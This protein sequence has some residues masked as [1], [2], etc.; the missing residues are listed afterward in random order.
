MSED[1]D[2]FFG[3]AARGWNRGKKAG[4]EVAGLVGL[5][6]ACIKLC[7][8]LVKWVVLFLPFTVWV[9]TRTDF[10]SK[11]LS[12]GNLA[13]GTVFGFFTIAFLIGEEP[14]DSMSMALA[15]IF[16][17]SFLVMGLIQ[18]I[19]AEVRTAKGKVHS[20]C[21]GKS[22]LLYIPFIARM[23][24]RL[25]EKGSRDY[26]HLLFEPFM[27]ISIGYLLSG[28]SQSEAWIIY[29][30]TASL[31]IVIYQANLEAKGDKS[32]TEFRDQAM[33]RSEIKEERKK[34]FEPFAPPTP[35]VHMVQLVNRQPD[36]ILRPDRDSIFS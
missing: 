32:R 19:M 36:P 20:M 27:V 6:V 34:A 31:G 5:F 12:I 30:A 10:G 7:I 22:W 11:F 8:Q 26:F 33:E 28:I 4:Q 3:N 15:N 25:S 35:V 2:D 13:A 14:P 18:K 24:Y 23:N 16:L 17:M 21:I 29:S 1:Y 9:F